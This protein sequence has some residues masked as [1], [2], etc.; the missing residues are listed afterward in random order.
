[1]KMNT[2]EVKFY[3]FGKPFKT[4]VEAKSQEHAKEVLA[5]LIKSKT[6]I[7]STEISLS[8]PEARDFERFLKTIF[9]Q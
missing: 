2:Y 1:M 4:K 7:V 6:E 9:G 5:E 8:E 3:V